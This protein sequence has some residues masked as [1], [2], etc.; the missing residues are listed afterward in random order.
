M[1]KNR[2]SLRVLEGRP[3]FL[4]MLFFSLLIEVVKH[5]QVSNKPILGWYKEL[6]NDPRLYQLTQETDMR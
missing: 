1:V 4:E 6:A 5:R 3:T 2:D